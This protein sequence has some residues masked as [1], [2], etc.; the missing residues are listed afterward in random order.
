MEINSLQNNS[1]QSTF[2]D[3][4]FWT[5]CL[6]GNLSDAEKEAAVVA[7]EEWIQCL[8]PETLQ[9]I[10]Q[11]TKSDVVRACVKILLYAI[12]PSLVPDFRK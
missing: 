8:D 7:I 4:S 12:D 10:L 2:F 6:L 5:H 9:Y 1:L 3:S 11:N